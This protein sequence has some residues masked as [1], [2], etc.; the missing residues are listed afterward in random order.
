M[1]RTINLAML[2]AI[3]A[4]ATACYE[5]RFEERRTYDSAPPPTTTQPTTTYGTPST[6]ETSSTTINNTTRETTIVNPPADPMDIDVNVTFE[7]VPS[8]TTTYYTDRTYV[9]EPADTEHV[10]FYESSRPDVVVYRPIVREGTHV[11]YLEPAGPNVVRRVYIDENRWRENAWERDQRIRD[12]FKDLARDARTAF[13][14]Q[15][16]RFERWMKI[17]RERRTE[18]REEK[19]EEKREE[20][21]EGR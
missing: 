21:N 12:R 16:D 19:R 1:T 15:K 13:E 4:A 6:S 10:Y 5:R 14:R 9:Y 2:V 7:D 3:T 11:Y 18:R 8:T 17:E 20:R